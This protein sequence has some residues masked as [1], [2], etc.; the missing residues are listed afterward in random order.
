MPCHA[1]D[2][3]IYN[4]A[5]T[6][7]GVSW[8]KSVS[9]RHL[10]YPVPYAA[11]QQETTFRRKSSFP[12]SVG[13]MQSR[14]A[15]PAFLPFVSALSGL[16]SPHACVVVNPVVDLLPSEVQHRL[17]PQ[18]IGRC[19]PVASDRVHFLNYSKSSP[20]EKFLALDF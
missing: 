3:P 18:S 16:S 1:Q 5:F 7:S 2:T 10:N 19:L 13:S 4:T 11:H 17:A 8:L 14:L 15:N 9:R 6:T 12:S 20:L